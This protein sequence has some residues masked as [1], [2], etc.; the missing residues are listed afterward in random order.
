MIKLFPRNLAVSWNKTQ[1]YLKKYKIL[2]T[3]QGNI[4]NVWHPNKYYYTFKSARKFDPW[5]GEQSINQN[6]IRTDTDI[7]I[8]RQGR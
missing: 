4:H 7:K 2:N 3:Q 1:E 6:Q 8:S 5:C